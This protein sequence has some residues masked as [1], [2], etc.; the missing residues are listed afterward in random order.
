MEKLFIIDSYAFLFKNYYALPKL[1][2]SSGEEVGALY[3]FIRLIFKIK[4]K[5]NYIVACYDSGKSFRREISKAYKAN[6]KKMDD[7]LLKQ[8]EKSRDVL[9]LLGIKSISKEGFEADDIIA[10]IANRAVDEGFEAI[11][12]GADKDL[13]QIISD[14][15]HMWDGKSDEYFDSEYVVKKYGVPPN[16]IFS[17]LVMVGDSSDNIK[18]V[19]GVG[20]KT[21]ARLINE[22]GDIDAIVSK[23]IESDDTKE[24][25]KI[26][27]SIDDINNAKRLLRL[28]ENVPLNFNIYDFRVDRFDDKGIIELAKRYEF[29]EAINLIDKTAVMD[30]KKLIKLSSQEFA[31]LDIKYFAVDEDTISYDDYYTDTDKKLL[32]DLFERDVPKYFYNLKKILHIAD[33]DGDIS[34]CDDIYIMYHLVNGG[35]RKPDITRIIQEKYFL[36]Q[37]IKTVYF[38]EIAKDLESKIEEYGI[39]ELYSNEIELSKVL[40][41]MEKNG[42]RFDVIEIEKLYVE[43]KNEIENTKND[44]KK[45]SEYDI[46]LN[47]PKQVSDFLFKKLN[48]K[49]DDKYQSIYR[50]KTGGYSTGEDVLKI[51][52]P[53]SPELIG[54]ILKHREYSKL[55]SFVET[56][57]GSIVDGKIHSTFDQ[58]TTQTGRLSSFNPNLQN[59]PVK[60]EMGQR[61]RNCVKA[62]DD[63]FL[64]SFDYSQIDLR[65]LA[66]LSDDE[67]LIRA[68]LNNEDIHKKT[69]ASI[70]N[71]DED[72]VDER[73]RSIAKIVNFGI[74]YG[75]TPLGLS[76]E[77]DISY[78]DAKTYIDNYFK[79]YSGVKK[80]IENTIIF[81]K[82]NGYVVNFAGR[83]RFIPD[84]TSVKRGLR[85][86]SERM[87]VN[88]PVQ[89]GSSDIIKKAMV[90]IYKKIKN[91]NDIKLILQIHDELIFEIKKSSL[92]KYINDIK[93]IMEN[94]FRLKVP[95]VV[96]VKYGERWSQL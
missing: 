88:M 16:K 8:I 90:M 14:R 96:N 85:L 3:G 22:Y 34:N 61:I 40:Y 48:L 69:A 30:K 63:Y 13:M 45:K 27:D 91:E 79:K 12:V 37:D 65:V 15:I 33:Y 51:L 21:A 19:S 50:T 38:K 72:R 84:I 25:K 42:V 23:A 24:L 47:S 20:P 67:E 17:Y 55:L 77:A 11:I 74:I 59:I 62:P 10:T 95:L 6:R 82:S 58:T 46:N 1:V 44:F 39:K 54:L 56:L 86:L 93:D 2:T 28:D 83:R 66:H 32:L 36:T 92:E 26:K 9:D 70:F 53:Y 60:T 4:E 80:W 81:A 76:L 49:L 73:L 57:K 35:F 52:K 7:A 18:G 78:E 43:F 75:Q 89:S 87:A 68:F 94:C 71:I 41:S 5:G 29:R 64:V 31:G